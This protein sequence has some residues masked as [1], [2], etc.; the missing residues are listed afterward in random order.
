MNPFGQKRQR[1][2]YENDVAGT[3]EHP[4][5]F[6]GNTNGFTTHQTTFEHQSMPF[7]SAGEVVAA[8]AGIFVPQFVV[9]S[10]E[11]S[12]GL[13]THRSSLP[14]VYTQGPPQSA[15][16][17]NGLQSFSRAAPGLLEHIQTKQQS[18]GRVSQDLGYLQGQ[19]EPRMSPLPGFPSLTSYED[20]ENRYVTALSPKKQ[21]KALISAQ[22]R[23]NIKRILHDKKCTTIESAQFRFWA[24]KM[25]TLEPLD[26]PLDQ[27][28]VCHEGKQ[29][30]VKEKLFMI[31]VRAHSDCQHGGRDKTSAQVRQRY[32]WVPKEL[33]A[34]FVKS[35]PTCAAR[36]NP[37]G[38]NL[39]AH[40]TPGLTSAVAQQTPPGSQD[41]S[42]VAYT[43]TQPV[44]ASPPQ[45][46]RQSLIKTENTLSRP[47]ATA[48]PMPPSPIRAQAA[49][50][51]NQALS[52]PVSM[53]QHMEN[54]ATSQTAQQFTYAMLN[55]QPSQLRSF[56]QVSEHGL[57]DYSSAGFIFDP[58]YTPN[59]S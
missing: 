20:T 35:C 12:L 59:G 25:F 44:M 34:R 38:Y 49:I 48:V 6:A 18:S 31:L 54:I 22:R 5:H 37:V 51:A 8:G 56:A 43:P 50:P 15:M 13:A 46:R 7:S 40:S 16:L 42:P 33:I 45:S 2:E 11:G 26:K 55:A 23:D 30:A 9:S 10:A 57:G 1:H 39:S 32:S 58:T 24:K 36:R 21:D 41:T 29:V 3:S 19:P 14:I 53:E 52:L 27:Q 47:P 4:Q 17:L 28:M